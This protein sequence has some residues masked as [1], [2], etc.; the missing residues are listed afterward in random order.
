M[1]SIVDQVGPWA[2]ANAADLAAGHLQVVVTEGP[3]DRDKR[4][5]WIDIDSPTRLVR[6]TVWDSGEAVLEVA[7]IVV[8]GV[9]AHENLELTSEFGLWQALGSAVAWA[10]GDGR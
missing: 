1:S 10:E 7:D 8:G 6:L 2:E 5:V 9:I 4:A 3:R